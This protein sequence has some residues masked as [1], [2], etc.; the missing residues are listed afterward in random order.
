MAQWNTVISARNLKVTRAIV[1]PDSLQIDTRFVDFRASFR[2]NEIAGSVSGL[3]SGATTQKSQSIKKPIGS[4][5]ND[6]LLRQAL[7]GYTARLITP[8]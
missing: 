5:H 3:G 6:G 7:L 1:I 2:L 8:P 4:E